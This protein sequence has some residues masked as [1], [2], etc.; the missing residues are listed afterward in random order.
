[1]DLMDCNLLVL[2]VSL[3]RFLRKGEDIENSAQNYLG[4]TPKPPEF[5]SL[6]TAMDT[7]TT[8]D[9]ERL[10]ITS[11]H[12]TQ[13]AP[14]PQSSKILPQTVSSRSCFDVSL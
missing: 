6:R 5:S 4:S 8:V 10:E 13:S 14:I 12:S 11:I 3:H 2:V 9:L 1:M 7:L